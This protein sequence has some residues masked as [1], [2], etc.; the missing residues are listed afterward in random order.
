MTF[1]KKVLLASVFTAAT[2]AALPAMADVAAPSSAPL[3]SWSNL[4][5]TGSNNNVSL[6]NFAAQSSDLYIQLTMTTS[7]LA[8]ISNND[9]AVLWLDTKTTG[10][11]TN[12]PNVGLKADVVSTGD[13]MVRNNASNNYIGAFTADQAAA[14]TTVTLYA[15][16]Y[17]SAGST[18]YNTF[19]LWTNPTATTWTQLL[20]SSAEAHNTYVS[21][22]TSISQVGFRT[23][24]LSGS[25]SILVSSANIYNSVTAVPEP[26][27]YAMFLAG[28]G[29][30]GA[31]A[32]RR[33][34]ML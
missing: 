10:D 30:V 11:H 32:R 33:R 27:T 21:G 22:L 12:V 18:T 25:D 15:H 34:H 9:F 23:A 7:S 13:Y 4:S 24:N 6:Q 28:L 8:K 1:C 16:L 2:T 3:A 14:G 5:L 26:E 29:I 31:I 19:D 20:A 17:K